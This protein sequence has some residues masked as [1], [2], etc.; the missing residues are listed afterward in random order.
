MNKKKEQIRPLNSL[1]PIP[2]QVS[3]YG[4]VSGRITLANSAVKVGLG[5]MGHDFR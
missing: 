2:F 1:P 5:L 4:H 3:R